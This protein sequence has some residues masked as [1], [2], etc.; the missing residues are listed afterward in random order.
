MLELGRFL[1]K[2]IFIKEKNSDFNNYMN[3]LYEILIIDDTSRVVTES[4][5]KVKGRNR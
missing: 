5:T 3:K 1:V 2:K 4:M